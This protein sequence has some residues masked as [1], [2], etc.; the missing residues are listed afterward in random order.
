LFFYT[1]YRAQ[2][3]GVNVKLMISLDGEKFAE[4]QFPANLRLEKHAFT[5]LQSTTG[6]VFLD[7]LQNDAFGQEYGTLF[8]SNSNGTFYVK[9]LDN[10]NRDDHGFVDFERLQ[11]VQGVMVMNQITNVDEVRRSDK[12]HIRTLLSTDDGSQWKTIDPPA[13]DY[14]GNPIPCNVREGEKCS[15]HLHGRTV[16]FYI[17]IDQAYMQTISR[18]GPVFSAKSAPGM[19]M[20]VGNVGAS[21]SEYTDGNT[22]LTRDGGLSWTEIRQVYLRITSF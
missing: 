16:R 12:K 20:A 21:L 1:A 13:K 10:S 14:Y 19:M 18:P 2:E 4:A 11:N 3:D 8:K 15:L 9:S 22:Y 6:A 5:I 7:A 17:R